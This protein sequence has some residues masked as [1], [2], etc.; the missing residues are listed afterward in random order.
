M[1]LIFKQKDNQFRTT[2]DAPY[3]GINKDLQ[4][5]LIYISQLLKIKYDLNEYRKNFS[6]KQKCDLKKKKMAI[7]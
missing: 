2:T 6:R 7:P 5:L 3:I 1:E 4:L